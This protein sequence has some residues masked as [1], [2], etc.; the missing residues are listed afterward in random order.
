MRQQRKK[1][2][3]FKDCPKPL[4]ELNGVALLSRWLGILSSEEER[5]IS[6]C[7]ITNDRFYPSFLSWKKA[8]MDSKIKEKVK[9]I[10][11]LSCSNDCRLGAVK[12]L[13]EVLTTELTSC[14][15]LVIA[16]DTIF[17]HQFRLTQFLQ[18]FREVQGVY[19]CTV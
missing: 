9:I 7:V 12:D 13:Q 6:I 14:P 16:G 17:S 5:I 2:K 15:V 11:D 19:L 8:L 3:K 1:W 4:M 18:R 10:N